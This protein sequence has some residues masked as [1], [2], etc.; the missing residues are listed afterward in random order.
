MR[1]LIIV[2]LLSLP[3]AAMAQVD[4][5]SRWIVNLN[6]FR[7]SVHNG[8]DSLLRVRTD[9]ILFGKPTN[10]GFASQS[11]LNDTAAAIRTAIGAGGGGTVTNVSRTNGYGITASVANST[12]TPNITIA[13]DS[14]VIYGVLRDS[15]ASLQAQINSLYDSL[16]AAPSLVFD[17]A[18]F[19]IVDDT[20]RLK[21]HEEYIDLTTLDFNITQ[22]GNYEVIAVSTG[23][24]F[25]PDP[26]L[27]TGKDI[28]IW[29]TAGDAIATGSYKPV[30]ASGSD[31]TQVRAGA[32]TTYKSMFGKWVIINIQN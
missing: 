3:F 12:T 7:F 28:I 17:S 9:S 29:N 2:L 5:K 10:L 26:L 19:T 4:L 1:K 21:E 14:S 31:D 32:I 27:F 30:N 16:A 18:D 15:I 8:T 25:L 13:V 20:V 24:I 22:P 11:A 6:G 23:L